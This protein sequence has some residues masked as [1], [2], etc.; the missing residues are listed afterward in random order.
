[1]GPDRT[2]CRERRIFVGVTD[3]PLVRPA[4]FFDAVFVD[5]FFD[6]FFFDTFFF[7]VLAGERAG[8]AFLREAFFD[9]AFV[10]FFLL[11]RLRETD[12]FAAF[13]FLPGAFLATFFFAGLRAAGLRRTAAFVFGA[14]LVEDF[15]LVLLT[16]GF[17][18]EV[19]LRM[20]GFREDARAMP[21]PVRFRFLLAAFLAGM[22]DSRVPRKTR[23]YTSVV[24]TWKPEIRVFPRHHEAPGALR[25]RREGVLDDGRCRVP[26]RRARRPLGRTD[27]RQSDASP[28]PRGGTMAQVASRLSGRGDNRFMEPY[29]LHY[30]DLAAAWY[31]HT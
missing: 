22:I 21:A 24:P 8:A 14:F 17:F 20:P 15:F 11:G 19:F 31:F 25:R 26:N 23:N 4:C 28:V 10:D 5:V 12:F 2:S 7:D 3:L 16:L 6:T 18:P 29:L 9:G 13:F 30:R 27:V 1:M